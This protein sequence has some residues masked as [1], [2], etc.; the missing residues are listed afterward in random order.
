[1]Q[2]TA[3]FHK[4][5][6]DAGL[7]LTVDVMDHATA[8]DAAVDMLDAHATTCHPSL[9]GF[10]R[11]CE[12]SASWLP[13][14]YDDLNVVQCA[15]QEAEILESPTACRQRVRGY[16]GHPL[17]VGAAGVGLTQQENRERR[18]EQP[19][20]VHRMVFFRAAI[21]AHLLNWSLGALAAPFG[22]IGA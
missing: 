7:P 3:S 9:G 15:R 17:I 10:L 1:V 2:P 8:H 6:A 19:H 16:I 12:G 20:I 4:Q 18:A 14:R 13:R 21:R 11:P 22:A 5:V